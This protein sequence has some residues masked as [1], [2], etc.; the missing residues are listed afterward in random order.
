[1]AATGTTI[2]VTGR[3][4]ER[5][6]ADGWLVLLPREGRVPRDLPGDFPALLAD[7]AK[8]RGFRGDAGKTL[9]LPVGRGRER[10]A[11]V[12]A[13]V[14]PAEKID[15]EALRLAAA[16]GARVARGLAV[17]HLAVVPAFDVDDPAGVSRAVAEGVLLAG[18]SFDRYRGGRKEK[19]AGPSRVTILLGEGAPAARRA[20]AVARAVARAISFARDLVNT[21]A[22]DLP[23][24][25]MAR[26]ATRAA[27]EYGLRARVLGPR[28]ISR[29]RMGGLLGVGRGSTHPPR[30]VHLAWKPR[31]RRPRA[32]LAWVGKGI[33][34]DSGG[35]DIKGAA[36]MVDMKSDMAGAAAVLAAMTAVA[37]LGLPVEVHGVLPLAENMISGDAL[38][39]GDVLK[40]RS[41]KTVEVDNTDAEGR[42][43]LADALDWARTR[44]RPRMMVDLATLTGACVVALGEEAAGVMANDD[45]VRDRVLEAGRA[46]GE[47]LWPLPLWDEYLDRLRSPVADLRNT[48]A[49]RWGG[50]LTAGLFLREF[51]GDVPWAHVD[52]AGPAWRSRQHPYW[53][54]GGTGFGVGTLVELARSF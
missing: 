47:R 38:R 31:G 33:T 13:G 45:Q 35:Y 9:S 37:E 26:V 23:P 27:R 28:E 39:P 1:M 49:S 32:R 12:L 51:V 54:R 53:G 24:A 3:V 52:I 6:R 41:G 43:V 10:K 46:A 36:H 18:Y 25:E 11:L 29:E 5:V 44:I 34:F 17:R 22:G 14:G 7:E 30:F 2:E 50:T 40:M 20:S 48:G 19:K 15:G 21:P 4:A 8:R 16:A 42:L